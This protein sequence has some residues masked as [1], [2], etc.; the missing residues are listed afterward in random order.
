[1]R[2]KL[3]GSLGI[4]LLVTGL[5]VAGHAEGPLPAEKI[6]Q[7]IEQ[8]NADRFRTRHQAYARLFAAGEKVLPQLR[9]ATEAMSAEQRYRVSQLIRKIR[10][11]V[12]KRGFA[13]ITG[14]DDGEIDL[15]EGMILIAQ[16]IDPVV[17]RQAILQQ[18]DELAAAVNRQLGDGVVAKRVPPQEFVDALIVVLRDE[19]KLSV[20]VIDYDNP[21]NSSLQCV[22]DTR[23]GL[24]ILIS[25]V[26]I[27]VAQ[28]LEVP[29]VGLS[30]PGRYMIKYD[31]SRA[32]LGHPR[33]D[34]I[35]DPFGNWRIVTPADIKNLSRWLDPDK[36]LV[37]SLRIDSLAR[38][39]RNLVSDLQGAGQGEK[40]EDVQ[41]VLLLLENRG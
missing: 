33:E 7:L 3:D 12:L 31:G 1:M 39:L 36:H 38:M 34:I 23:Q 15:D 10:V 19:F 2:I 18:L 21:K 8:L 13:K 32:P 28:R 30:V 5:A 11:A 20:N 22:L 24:P 35:I 29:V 25:H 26:A 9:R 14:G 4:L 41:R 40:A 27:S 37:P 16:I 17:D 6:D